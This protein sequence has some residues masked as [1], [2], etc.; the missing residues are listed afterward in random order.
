MSL[1]RCSALFSGLI[2]DKIGR[3]NVI[4][5]LTGGLFVIGALTQ[6]LLQFVNMSVDAK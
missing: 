4:R 6:L 3:K 5:A 1:Y 2:S